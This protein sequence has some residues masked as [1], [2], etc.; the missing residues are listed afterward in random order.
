MHNIGVIPFF[1]QGSGGFVVGVPAAF[2]SDGHNFELN[3]LRMSVRISNF[4]L[5]SRFCNILQEAAVMW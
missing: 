4:I 5:D 1:S 3:I 2:A